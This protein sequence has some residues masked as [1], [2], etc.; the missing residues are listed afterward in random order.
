MDNENE[1]YKLLTTKV[2]EHAKAACYYRTKQEEKNEL[3]D[4]QLHW[5][6]DQHEKSQAQL[7]KM[8]ESLATLQDIVLD[9]A[10]VIQDLKKYA[11]E[12]YENP[13]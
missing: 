3:H 13:E 5:L 12:D 4:G 2:N 11:P 1:K 9:Q 8:E 6:Y 7:K 10:A